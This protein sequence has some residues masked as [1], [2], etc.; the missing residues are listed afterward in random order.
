MKTGWIALIKDRIE[1]ISAIFSDGKLKTNV[2]HALPFWV[3]SLIT[4]VIA[5][6]YTRLFNFSEGLMRQ[7]LS[8]HH[9]LIFILAPVNM[10]IGW[11]IVMRFAPGAR[12]SGI[13][14]V[15]AAIEL[16]AA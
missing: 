3:A 4:G 7:A 15:M 11:Y 13:P 9:W 16:P 6:G 10:L 12:G 1:R 5:V 8:W 14:Q 2:L